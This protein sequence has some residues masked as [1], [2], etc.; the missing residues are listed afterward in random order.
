MYGFTIIQRK[1]IQK[2]KLPNT[3]KSISFIGAN[4]VEMFFGY[5]YFDKFIKDKIFEENNEFIIGIDG[6]VLN[7]QQLKN[8]YGFSDYL[9]LIS[10]L[11]KRK[12]VDFFSLLK[13]EFNGFVFDKLN[14]KLF[15]FNNKTGTKQI[16]YSSFNNQTIISQSLEIIIKFKEKNN[17]NSQLNLQSVYDMLTFGATIENA[18]LVNEVYRIQAGKFIELKD[19]LIIEKEYHS[20]NEVEENSSSKKQLLQTLENYFINALQLEYKK[21]I[22]YNY[23]HFALLSGG[24]DSRMNVVLANKLGYKNETLCFSVPKYADDKISEQISKNYNLK[25]HFISLDHG[26]YMTE[27]D[28]NFAINNGICFFTS[29]AHYN[30]ALKKLNINNFGLVHTGQIGDGILGSLLSKGNNYCSKKISS[31][32]LNKLRINDNY[33]ANYK[34]EE[35][36]KLYQNVFNRTHTGSF[37]TESHQTYLTSPFLD[38]DVIT[39]CLSIPKKLK[40]NQ[41]IYLEWIAKFHPEV[42][43][44]VWERTGFKP[45]R[46]WKTKLSRY[47]NRI[48]N[49]FYK[50]KKETYKMSMAPEDYWLKNNNKVAT[51]FNSFQQENLELL[52]DNKEL[53]SDIK[54]YYITGGSVE[55]AIVLTILKAVKNYNLKI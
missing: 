16:F 37:T 2:E 53:Y 4:D 10:S 8:E 42:T 25:H 36:F 32:F 47:T 46:K 14:E 11:F 44:F 31:L 12:K 18:T 20:Y 48:K 35:V 45:N 13:G 39:T 7:L 40:I 23:S 34:N 22:E 50:I 33:L 17:I 38:D 51:F 9:S 1:N 15:F 28:E 54:T 41:N 3:R 43:K 26:S 55:K 30:Y 21:D 29:S 5:D 49:D 19:L 24:L 27:L 52:K 6:V